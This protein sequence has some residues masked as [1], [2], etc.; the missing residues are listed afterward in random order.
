MVHFPARHG[1]DDII[2]GSLLASSQPN[3]IG[4]W[5]NLSSPTGLL[6]V[7][8]S[9]KHE[10]P[11]IS[12]NCFWNESM[13]THEF[14]WKAQGKIMKFHEQKY[15]NPC[16]WKLSQRHFPFVV[17]VLGM[18]PSGA[19][20]PADSDGEQPFKGLLSKRAWKPP[21]SEK[22]HWNS[23]FSHEE[24]W[25]SIVLFL[26]NYDPGWWFGTWIVFF[27]MLE[28]IIPTDSYFSAG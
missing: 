22:G 25:F 1:A 2:S 8:R 3:S 27:H 7:K 12:W 21:T 10:N 20:R 28:T 17:A 26:A 9:K 18:W 13:K 19:W 15:E 4:P 11:M 14:P 6:S 5:F 24:W 16:G 23:E